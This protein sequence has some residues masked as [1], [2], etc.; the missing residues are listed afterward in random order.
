MVWQSDSL[1]Y[2]SFGCRHFLNIWT[3]LPSQAS[4]ETAEP[5]V[6]EISAMVLA[7]AVG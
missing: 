4:F 1:P 3:R 7:V 6:A 5:S 2:V